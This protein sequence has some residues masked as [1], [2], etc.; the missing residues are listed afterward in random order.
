VADMPEQ[1]WLSPLNKILLFGAF[2]IKL[3]EVTLRSG[4]KLSLRYVKQGDREVVKVKP[5]PTRKFP[6]EFVPCGTFEY[7]KVSHS[8]W[9]E[10]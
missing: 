10:E 5:I 3:R 1:N 6:N 2:K 7:K 8:S 9:L 4:Q